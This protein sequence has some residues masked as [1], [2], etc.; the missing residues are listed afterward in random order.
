MVEIPEIQFYALNVT[1]ATL[2]AWAH[3][4]LPDLYEGSLQNRFFAL[5]RQAKARAKR[6]RSARPLSHVSRAPLQLRASFARKTRKNKPV[7]H[8]ITKDTLVSFD[9]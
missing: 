3:K 2:T 8:S 5:F 4:F 7:L 6:V 1:H 9:H